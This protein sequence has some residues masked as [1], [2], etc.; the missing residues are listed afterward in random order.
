MK[1][2]LDA[3]SFFRRVIDEIS[4]K[5]NSKGS[6]FVERGIKAISAKDLRVE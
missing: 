5:R 2:I 3:V 4:P 6:G 1:L